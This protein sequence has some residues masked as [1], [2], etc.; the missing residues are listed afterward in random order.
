MNLTTD[1]WI[2]AVQADGTRDLFSLQRL[3]TEAHS[4]RDLAVKPHE[5]IAL[6]R[7]LLCITQAALNGPADEDEWKTCEPLIQSRVKGY[8]NHWA[9][10]FELFGN[11]QRFL[12][13][14]NLKPGKATDEGNLATKLDLALATGNNSI[15]FDNSAG[16]SRAIEPAR[17]ALNLLTFQCFSPGG[18]IG[19]ARW[20]DRETPGK[21][22]SAHAPC[23]PSSMLH[24]FVLRPHLL[25]TI[26]HNLLTNEIIADTYVH[27]TGRPLWEIP[28]STATDSA[29]IRNATHTYL[30]RLVPL[31]RAIS[32]HHAGNFV[33]L[34]NGLEYPP[35]PLF[36]EATCTII[37]RKDELGLLPASTGRSIWRQLLAITVRRK[38]VADQTSGPLALALNS[39]AHDATL[40]IGALVTDKAKIEDVVEAIYSVPSALFEPAGRTAYEHGVTHADSIESALMKSIG[41]YAASLKIDSPAYD[42]ARVHFWTRVEQNLPALFDVAREL[43]LPDELPCTAWGQA[44]RAAAVDAYQ[45]TCPCRTPRQLEAFS[46]GLRQLH[47]KP[48]P[49]STKPRKSKSVA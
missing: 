46:L 41:A 40:W 43:I 36:R 4:V 35:F 37:Q 49:S 18:R 27:G 33:V 7:L 5:R 1:P 38:S 21:G 34:A 48:T 26:A 15:L 3:F 2:P 6:M 19:V 31:S 42:R 17:A 30:G 23:N 39:D 13:L 32:L 10:A 16:E 45:Q 29:A 47:R 12:Q 22:S 9:P 14:P 8:L 11:G 20:N 44:V 28:V 25:A 24:T